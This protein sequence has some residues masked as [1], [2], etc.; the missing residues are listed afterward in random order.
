M[1]STVELLLI[2]NVKE[3]TQLDIK[4][5]LRNP[6]YFKKKNVYVGGLDCLLYFF[7]KNID[8][9]EFVKGKSLF[10]IEAG[11]EG[12]FK[13]ETQRF[14]NKIEEELV[15]YQIPALLFPYLRAEI[16][17]F[18]AN[19]GYGNFV[20]PL[21]NIYQLASDTLKNIQIVVKD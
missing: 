13:P 21:I 15:K 10:Y 8:P 4:I 5:A 11:I 3:Q 12:F 6:T 2:E 20:L 9:K 16:T 1:R 17:S 7:E 18:L 19:A 14:E